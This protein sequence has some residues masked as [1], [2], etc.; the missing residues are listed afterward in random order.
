MICNT[1]QEKYVGKIKKRREDCI[2]YPFIYLFFQYMKFCKKCN[3]YKIIYFDIEN[4]VTHYYDNKLEIMILLNFEKV[5]IQKL[6][7]F[8]KIK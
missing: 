6:K 2:L 3:W 4:R 1:E 8:N 5:F 7:Y